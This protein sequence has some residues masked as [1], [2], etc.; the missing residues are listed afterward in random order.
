[1]NCYLI[2][3]TSRSETL[4]MSKI[5]ERNNIPFGLINTPREITSSCSISIKISSPYVSYCQKIISNL[6]FYTFIGIFKYKG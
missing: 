3:F 5:L 4:K 2:S 1:M 6:S